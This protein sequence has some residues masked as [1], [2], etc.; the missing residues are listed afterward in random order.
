MNR[1]TK[2]L[3]EELNNFIAKKDRESVLESRAIHI[4]ESAT[5]LLTFI[6]DNFSIEEA[7]DLEKRF[8]NSIRVGDKSKFVRGVRK[9][10]DSKNVKSVSKNSD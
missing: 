1:P 9:I 7:A 4:I 6:N 2:S 10:R 3:L 8:I 5:N